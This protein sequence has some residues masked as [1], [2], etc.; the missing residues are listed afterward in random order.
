MQN[1]SELDINEY[2]GNYRGIVV[3][4]NDPLVKGRLKIYVPGVYPEELAK[5]PENLPWAEPAMPIFGGSWTNEKQDKVDPL[6][7]DLNVE[8]GH[9]MPPHTSV[10]ELDGAQLWVFF[11][12]GDPQFPIYFSACQSGDGWLSE[13]DNQHV[14]HTD[15]VRVRIDETPNTPDA[16]L[17]TCY[18]DTYNKK[19]NEVSKTMA[20]KGQ[21]TRVDIEIWNQRAQAVHLH[22]KGDVNMHIEGDLYEELLGDRHSTHYGDHYIY[23][24]GDT[25][26]VIDGDTFKIETGDVAYEQNGMNE[27]MRKGDDKY[28][29]DGNKVENLHNDLEL[30]VLGDTVMNFHDKEDESAGLTLV[31]DTLNIASYGRTR[32]YSNDIIDVIGKEDV[33]IQVGIWTLEEQLKST[34]DNENF[35]NLIDDIK[36]LK[37]EHRSHPDSHLNILTTGNTNMQIG[38]EWN[39][40]ARDHIDFHTWTHFDTL[41]EDTTNL[42][43]KADFNIL[44][45]QNRL[46]ISLLST[47]IIIGTE[48][49]T[50]S[51]GIT[52]ITSGGNTIVTA[53]QIHL[54]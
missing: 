35:Y 37:G 8:C 31:A 4:N 3:H 12:R 23:H 1:S 52:D 33:N 5:V 25:L 15:N 43:A 28:I 13:T 16:E 49:T 44:T 11:E 45:W 39:V 53:P 19:C 21:H 54:N 30:V 7:D 14:M 42:T 9:T 40:E 22:I 10:N 18:F 50:I 26:E 34:T 47:T 48:F 6:D 38:D 17:S 27:V 32:L 29:L 46:D 41:S 51:G 20:K 36:G 2:N 24:K